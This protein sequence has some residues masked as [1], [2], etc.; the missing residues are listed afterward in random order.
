M[1]HF[2]T[3]RDNSNAYIACEYPNSCPICND[4]ISPINRMENVNKDINLVS[5]F[6]SCPSCRKTFVTHYAFNEKF[7][8]THGTYSYYSLKL[9]DS[10]PK[11]PNVQSFDKCINGLSTSFVEIYNQ[12]LASETYQLNQLS[13]I[14]YRKALEFLIKDYCIH[15]NPD[16]EDKIKSKP[17]G[18]V[19]NDYVDSD[20]LKKLSKASVWIGNDET[21]YI[22]KFEDKDINDLKRFISAT[23]AYITYELTS[24][25]AE[26]LVESK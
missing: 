26:Q 15:R 14:G 9:I 2:L 17:L 19:I 20:K 25:E 16:S 5:L 11:R 18:Q 21:H 3:A 22:R 6:F 23:V 13:G 1:K 4:K 12:A 8:E 7:K 10:F 24:D